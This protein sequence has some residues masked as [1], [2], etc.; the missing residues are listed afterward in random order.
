MTVTQ[1][2]KPQVSYKEY[3]TRDTRPPTVTVQLLVCSSILELIFV[4]QDLHLEGM[5]DTDFW[6][7]HADDNGN[8]ILA[9]PA[10]VKDSVVRDLTKPRG[11]PR[12]GRPL[13]N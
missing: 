2:Y 4:D 1:T 12:F 3:P 10:S 13:R 9:S 7:V 6:S 8:E 5:E 11:L